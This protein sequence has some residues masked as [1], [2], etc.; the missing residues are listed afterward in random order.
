MGLGASVPLFVTCTQ[1]PESWLCWHHPIPQGPS[2]RS[3]APSEGC[4][5]H[6]RWRRAPQKGPPLP[7][8]CQLPRARDRRPR[9]LLDP[10]WSVACAVS[11]RL[12]P[13]R[14]TG[15]LSLEPLRSYRTLV[16]PVIALPCPHL[17]GPFLI[18]L[19]SPSLQLPALPSL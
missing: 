5:P 19:E 15:L 11:M 14:G 1:A 9:L 12:C 13:G 17:R 3:S 8:A 10:Q 6:P 2:L 4:C 18:S 7:A 16:T